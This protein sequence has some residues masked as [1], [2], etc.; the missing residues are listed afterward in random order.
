M[1]EIK[2]GRINFVENDSDF[3]HHAVN[4]R[5][6]RLMFCAKMPTC[7]YFL[8]C[9]GSLIYIGSS[10][11]PSSRILTHSRKMSVD[12]FAVY[13]FSLSEPLARKLEWALIRYLKPKGNVLCSPEENT[14]DV[15]T[16]SRFFKIKSLDKIKNKME[17]LGG[18][19]T[20]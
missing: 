16:I 2:V 6:G 7:V 18:S 8:F 4:S 19:E 11:C 17:S 15:K 14:S 20:N 3:I 12:D 1:Q 9:G 5:E 13:D 10:K